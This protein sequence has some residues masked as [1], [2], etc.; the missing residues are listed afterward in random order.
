MI[1]FTQQPHASYKRLSLN[2]HRKAHIWQVYV[3]PS[4]SPC[5][6]TIRNHNF[7]HRYSIFLMLMI[8]THKNDAV[9]DSYHTVIHFL[10][11]H[12]SVP[13]SDQFLAL[14]LLWHSQHE[15]ACGLRYLQH[16]H[17]T[18]HTVDSTGGVMKLGIC[19][20]FWVIEYV[21]MKRGRFIWLYISLVRSTW[22]PYWCS[23][24][25]MAWYASWIWPD[26]WKFPTPAYTMRWQRWG[27]EA[28]WRRPGIIS[29]A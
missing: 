14:F 29:C 2:G 6:M 11:E 8:T 28:F 9:L 15:Q 24:R 12:H 13:A 20:R 5:V 23:E 16:V 4:V 26:T 3:M 27:R 7:H 22:R 10:F 1:C 25:K 21:T 19:P 17:V 18:W